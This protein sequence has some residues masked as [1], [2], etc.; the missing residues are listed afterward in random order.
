MSV[1]PCCAATCSGV[2]PTCARGAVELSRRTWR[3]ARIALSRYQKQSSDEKRSHSQHHDPCFIERSCGV[4]KSVS[5]PRLVGWGPLQGSA[6]RTRRLA[7]SR[8]WRCELQCP[9]H[10]ASPRGALDRLISEFCRA[11]GLRAIARLAA[12][13]P[14]GPPMPERMNERATP[15]LPARTSVCASRSA[16]ALMSSRM[17]SGLLKNA[18]TWSARRGPMTFGGGGPTTLQRRNQMGRSEMRGA[19]QPPLSARCSCGRADVRVSG[20]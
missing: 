2:R 8:R 19:C 4:K 11:E 13:R 5:A 9:L 18:A 3:V 14:S 7:S 16:P 20:A 12:H 17:T 15:R 6:E 10:S 1:D